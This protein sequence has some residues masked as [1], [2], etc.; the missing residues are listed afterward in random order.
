MT[1]FALL[2]I[3]MG[4]VVLAFGN[5]LVLLGAGIGVL[6]GVGVLRWLPGSP[7]SLWWWIVPIGLAILF[8]IGGGLAKGLVSII[9]LA[10]GALAGG[11]VV[12]VV[13]DLFGLDQGW[14]NLIL[15]LVGAVIGAILMSG[16]KDWAVIV[17]AA[18][19][20]A[21][22][23]VRGLQM[24]L[25]AIQGLVATLISLVLAG[26][27]IAYHGGFLGKGKSSQKK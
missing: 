12:L 2:V 15:A 4:L 22:L 11:A 8:G 7:A 18:V 25:P 20:G 14:V 24:W 26:L 21:L 1:A 19:V 13:M 16:L 3:A 5:R 10:F 9:S 17:L 27:A 6:L 23:V